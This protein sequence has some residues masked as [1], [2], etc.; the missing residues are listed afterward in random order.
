[1]AFLYVFITR[2]ENEIQNVL[3]DYFFSF[4]LKLIDT[5]LALNKGD[6]RAEAQV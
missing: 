2:D 4:N 5:Y 6:Y 3:S 1:M